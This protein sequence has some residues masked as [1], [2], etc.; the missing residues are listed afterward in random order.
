MDAFL[1]S[2]VPSRSLSCVVM[3]T[4]HVR[5]RRR[6]VPES[7]VRTEQRRRGQRG[8]HGP[9]RWRGDAAA[10]QRQHAVGHPEGPAGRVTV[11]QGAANTLL[12]SWFRALSSSSSSS[13]T[14]CP[15]LSP[16][17]GS[18]MCSLI[19]SYWSVGVCLWSQMWRLCRLF[20]L[21]CDKASCCLNGTCFNSL[22]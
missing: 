4:G 11:Q 20:L 1:C 8:Q 12:A 2:L 3:A 14:S 9:D 5:H 16:L 6:G 17:L 18:I 15:H 7:A 22:Y 21:M 13:S 19:P 10:G